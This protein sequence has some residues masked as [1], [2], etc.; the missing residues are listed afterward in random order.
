VRPE[1]TDRNDN[2]VA[3]TKSTEGL[4]V[5][6]S[7]KVLKGGALMPQANNEITF[8][9]S[10]AGEIVATDN[11]DPADLVAFPS[12]QRRAYGGLALVIVR[13][14]KGVSGEIIMTAKSPGIAPAQIFANAR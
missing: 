12:K 7:D 3:D 1:V 10:G 2:V 14:K 6:S 4:K 11:G 13:G 9:I 8:E 5:A